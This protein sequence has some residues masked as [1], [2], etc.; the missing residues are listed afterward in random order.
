MGGYLKHLDRELLAGG[1]A[2]G[3]V[4]EAI[5]ALADLALYQVQ[6]RLSLS[7]HPFVACFLLSGN[8][9]RRSDE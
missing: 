5:G 7:L 8:F 6:F 1:T 9:C 2:S 4:H 3:N